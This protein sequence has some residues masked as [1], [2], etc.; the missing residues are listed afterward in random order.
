MTYTLHVHLNASILTHTHTVLYIYTYYMYIQ[1]R[2]LTYM[3]LTS[4]LQTPFGWAK[5][6]GDT[7]TRTLLTD[8]LKVR[9]DSLQNR[10]AVGVEGEEESYELR[11]LEGV[12]TLLTSEPPPV[13]P[14]MNTAM[15]CVPS[16]P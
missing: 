6:A 2:E 5:V 7:H 3:L 10:D 4:I 9:S 14:Y 15:V 13:T 1:V 16:P 11:L 12:R 8:I